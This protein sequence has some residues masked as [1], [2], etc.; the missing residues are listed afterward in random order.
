MYHKK[1]PEE[2]TIHTRMDCQHSRGFGNFQ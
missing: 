2:L 1:E